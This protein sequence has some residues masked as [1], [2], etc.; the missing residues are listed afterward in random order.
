MNVL[1]T[2][3]RRSADDVAV[4]DLVT[5]MWTNFAKYGNPNTVRLGLEWAPVSATAPSRHLAIRPEPE[6][7]EQLPAADRVHR[8]SR[9]FSVYGQGVLDETGH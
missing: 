1:L 6:M 3:W 5:T 9:L 2:P 8:L 7:R 4:R